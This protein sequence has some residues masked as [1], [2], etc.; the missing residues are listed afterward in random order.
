MEGGLQTFTQTYCNSDLDASLAAHG[1][2]GFIDAGDIKYKNR[3][4]G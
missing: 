4:C 1:R 2:Y 3:D